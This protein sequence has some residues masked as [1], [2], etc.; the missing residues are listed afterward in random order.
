MLPGAVSQ[1]AFEKDPGI[2][3]GKTAVAYCTIGVRS[4]A[5]S[6]KMNRK[7][8]RVLSLSGGL[9]AWLLEGGKIYQSD[10]WG[11]SS[12]GQTIAE[13]PPVNYYNYRGDYEHGHIAVDS[14]RE[15]YEA[16]KGR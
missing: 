12:G 5:F 4:G 10:H 2:A 16:I 14:S 6:Q 13:G 3:E 1:E 9:L 8:G 7:E 11:L 15:V